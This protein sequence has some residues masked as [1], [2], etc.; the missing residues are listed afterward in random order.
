VRCETTGSGLAPRAPSA[1]G[2]RK[3]ALGVRFCLGVALAAALGAAGC[4]LPGRRSAEVEGETTGA[5][6]DQCA[7]AVE[8]M[9]FDLKAVDRSH[10]IVVAE[11]KVEG[12]LSFHEVRLSIKVVHLEGR[13]FR[14][15]ADAAANERGLR[16]GAVKKAR[17]LFFR[18]LEKTTDGF[19]D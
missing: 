15:E 10:Q 7:E 1:K 12:G 3:R 2:A 17:K 6:L 5:I 4:L 18:E 8:R 16:A 13:R 9:H 11:G 14:V 19:Q